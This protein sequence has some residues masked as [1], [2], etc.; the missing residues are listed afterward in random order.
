LLTIE[1]GIFKLRDCEGDVKKE[2]YSIEDVID[3]F[4]WY[5]WKKSTRKID[6]AFGLAYG[7]YDSSKSLYE[8]DNALSQRIFRQGY[9]EKTADFLAL[10]R[11]ARAVEDKFEFVR[12]DNLNPISPTLILKKQ[13]GQK[14]TNAAV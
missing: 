7:V 13:G 5:A 9:D 2:C 1:G 10:V 3:Y 14:Y 12:F 11:V 8:V 6:K 4:E